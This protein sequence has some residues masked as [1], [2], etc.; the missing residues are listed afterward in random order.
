MSRTYFLFVIKYGC[1]QKIGWK[2]EISCEIED[3]FSHKIIDP[4]RPQISRKLDMSECHSAYGLKN[5][6][7]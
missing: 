1:H 2:Y 3:A 6:E 4:A 5:S 7:K